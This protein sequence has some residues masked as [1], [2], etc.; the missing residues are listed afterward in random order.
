MKHARKLAS[1]LLALVM[2]FALATT[3][4]AAE[5][6]T[7]TTTGT[8]TVAN[9]VEGRTYTAYKVFDVTYDK[10]GHYSYT[11]PAFPTDDSTW[12]SMVR[13]YS[14]KKDSGLIAHVV[15]I[16]NTESG[17]ESV[18]FT[19]DNKFSPADFA[20]YLKGMLGVNHPTGHVLT[21][22]ADGTVSVSDL[23]LGYYFVASDTGALCNLT[24]TNPNA[25]IHD[26]NDM[27]F[28]KTADATDVEVGQTVNYTI[29]G[30]V[31]AYTGFNT[32]TYRI[33]DTMTDGLTF[34]KDVKVTVDGTDVTDDCTVNYDV[35]KNAN[36]FT[37]TVPV[38]QNKYKIGAEIKATYS[39]TV[40]QKA[41][42]VVSENAAKLIYSNDPTT[43][44][45]KTITP[46]VVKVYTSQIVIDKYETGKETTKLPNAE[47]VLYKEVTSETGKS[48]VYYKWNDTDKKV[49][50]VED[51]A[52]ATVA[53]T[54][55]YGMTYFF[56]LADGTYYL[57]ETKAPAGYNRLEAPVEL[58]VAGSTTETA[59]LSVTAKVPNS[60]GT[61]L[62]STGGMGTT[63]FYVLGFALVMGAVVLLVTKKRMS[64]ANG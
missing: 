34:K 15:S 30:K 56:G 31:P 57:V 25:T 19:T 58:T 12:Y 21:E 63:V 11:L 16:D 5:T 45:T 23:P 47:F 29:T 35:N 37:V 42:A 20:A 62:P 60:T 27:H 18:F 2:V 24:T 40:N 13:A 51:R 46:P 17:A 22:Q 36:S 39:A 4:F 1:L 41:I 14:T 48:T 9:P 28:G 32:Y 53:V 49:E 7:T 3:A 55:M 44:E 38:L 50:W 43:G 26:K 59:K 33:E 8:I 6:G 52:A 64:D 10:D 61:V 54:D